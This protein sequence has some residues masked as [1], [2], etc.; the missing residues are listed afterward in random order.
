MGV[1]AAAYGVLAGGQRPAQQ[2]PSPT[3]A[4]AGTLPVGS[5]RMNS[6][7]RSPALRV[8]GSRSLGA[9]RNRRQS[10]WRVPSM[11]RFSICTGLWLI[12]SEEALGGSLDAL[13]GASPPSLE[14]HFLPPNPMALPSQRQDCLK[15]PGFEAC[16]KTPLWAGGRH[17]LS[18]GVRSVVR[19]CEQHIWP[20]LAR[21]CCLAGS[22]ASLVRTEA[23]SPAA[24]SRSTGQ[25]LGFGL[26]G[27]HHLLPFASFKEGGS[28]VTSI[29]MSPQNPEEGNKQKE[30][31]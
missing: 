26:W 7:A 25:R 20:L 4:P 14:V 9:A 18:H 30:E 15:G 8:S 23:I 22:P 29:T 21:G 11:P 31:G 19:G 16:K 5:P 10:G 3:H 12:P 6:E 13:T 17:S 27:L 1:A 2:H 24:D 28:M